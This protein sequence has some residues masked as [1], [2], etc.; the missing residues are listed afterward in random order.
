MLI[1]ADLWQEI[2]AEKGM[3]PPTIWGVD[4]GTSSAQSAIACYSTRTGALE[5]VAAFPET[6]SL[7]ERGLA[8]GVGNLYQ[9]M[10]KEGDLLIAGRRVSEIPALLRECRNDK[11]KVTRRDQVKVTHPGLKSFSLVPD[12]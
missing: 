11:V 4:L 6:P 1:D 3:L 9:R 12:P 5:V 10:H 8:D 2:E 7:A